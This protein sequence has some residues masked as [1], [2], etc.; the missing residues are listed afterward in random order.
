[1]SYTTEEK[2]ILL[3]GLFHDIGKFE[4]RCTNNPEKK[5]HQQLGVKFVSQEGLIFNF[6][7]ILG[8]DGFQA[9][10]NIIAEHH[11]REAQD[12]TAIV[13]AADH[14]SASERVEKEEV[15]TDNGTFINWGNKHLAS[16][17]S[18]IELL[19]N[20]QKAPRYFRQELLVKE[21]SRG[22]KKDKDFFN[23]IIPEEM[24]RQEQASGEFAY[25]E[26]I[27]KFFTEDVDAVL[28]LYTKEEDFGNIINLLLLVFEKYLWCIPDFTG[29]SETDISLYNHLKDVAGIAL[30]LYRAQKAGNENRLLLII[31]DIPGIQKYIFNVVNKKPAKILRGRSIFVQVFTRILVNKFLEQL[32]LPETNVVMSAGGKFYILAPDTEAIRTKVQEVNSIIDKH[33]YNEFY[34]ELGFNSAVYGFNAADL[35]TGTI[36]FGEIVEKATI[37]LNK[38]KNLQFS[39]VLFNGDAG[40]YTNRIRFINAGDSDSVKCAV[41]EMPIRNKFSGEIRVP[42]DN[43]FDTLTVTKQV[44]IEYTI[45]EKV[46]RDNTLIPIN[47]DGLSINAENITRFGEGKNGLAYNSCILLNPNLGELIEQL[48]N[49]NVL[50]ANTSYI[51]VANFCSRNGK[52]IMDFGEISNCNN[53]AQYLT[54]IKGDIDNLGLIMAYGL[55]RDGAEQNDLT[56]LSRT[57]TMSTHLKYF[58]SFFLNGF[59]ESKTTPHNAETEEKDRKIYTIFA[60]GDDLMLVTPQSYAL[61]FVNELNER[62]SE[63][64]CRNSEVHISYSVTHFKHHT[65]VRIVA[66]IAE[67]NQSTGKKAKQSEQ[68]MMVTLGD[69]R[70]FYPENDKAATIV[71]ETIVKNSQ[72]EKLKSQADTVTSWVEDEHT[73]FSHRLVRKLLDVAEAIKQ[74]DE[75]GDAALL[76]WHARLSYTVNRLLKNNRGEFHNREVG[77]FFEQVLSF[78]KNEARELKEMLYPLACQ[79]IY[80]LRNN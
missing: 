5:R 40:V 72:L 21:S 63:F 53:G 70:S 7:K 18:K 38:S 39:S 30:A 12:L 11:N 31:G 37:E 1:M 69:P 66:D 57:T 80:N 49:G 28:T 9:F 15:E 4:Q 47:P 55:H 26:E 41:T 60:G 29:S 45:G 62:F 61:T 73:K 50:L 56:S 71:Y 32:I 20:E 8:E 65:P 13:R 64:V 77:E 14:L 36:T 76:L 25:S 42:V 35:R 75:T 44:Q 10:A 19:G 17:F 78:N 52:E 23:I 51:E 34:M 22:T 54:L 6:K 43:G 58:F 46:I 3:G 27:F 48:K 2:I 16:V 59:M 68:R 33:L 67:H 74:Y 79:V 24:N